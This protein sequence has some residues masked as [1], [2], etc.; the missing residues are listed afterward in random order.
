MIRTNKRWWIVCIFSLIP[1]SASWSLPE[2]SEQ[3]I[4]IESD[5]ASLDK[6]QGQLVYNGNVKM[7]Q[8][9]LNIEADHITITR[10]ENGLKEVIAKGSPAKYEQVISANEGKTTAYGQTIIYNTQE[11]ELTL[12]K[13]AGLEKQGNRFVGE[14]I[15]YL[16]KE[17]RV[18][19][20]S[21]EPQERIKMVIQPKQDKENK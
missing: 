13:E 18:K 9:S 6:L 10:S 15:V 16:I 21:P 1:T 20:D 8:G 4:Y 11:D 14:K 17:Q 5:N 12:L 2:D 19:A 3:E 7:T